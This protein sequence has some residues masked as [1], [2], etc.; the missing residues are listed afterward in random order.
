MEVTT[1]LA[2]PDSLP[3]TERTPSRSWDMSGALGNALVNRYEPA[4]TE[5][6]TPLIPHRF[7]IHYIMLHL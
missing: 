3:A 7:Y 5:T 2:M 1:P 6:R 4:A